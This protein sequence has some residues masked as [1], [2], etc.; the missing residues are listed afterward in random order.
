MRAFQH[1]MA[2]CTIENKLHKNKDCVQCTV[3]L[4][5]TAQGSCS[6]ALAGAGVCSGAEGNVRH[7]HRFKTQT[8]IQTQLIRCDVTQERADGPL[9]FPAAQS[10]L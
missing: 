9:G 6:G 3:R 2:G 8:Q 10:R 4:G 7:T 5:E 1:A